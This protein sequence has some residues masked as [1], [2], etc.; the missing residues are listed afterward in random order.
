MNVQSHLHTILI[1]DDDN[2]SIELIKS[3]LPGEGYEFLS[4]TNSQD[5]L[6]RL[7]G[8]K[9][10]SLIVVDYKT[11]GLDFLIEAKKLSPETPRIVVTTETS[12]SEIKQFINIGEVYRFYSKPL[13][14]DNFLNGFYSAIGHYEEA[15]KGIEESKYKDLQIRKLLYG[16]EHSPVSVIITDLKGCIEYVNPKFIELTGY[17]PEEVIGKNPKVL[18]SGETHGDEYKNMWKMLSAGKEWHGEF[19]N[20]KKNGDLYWEC[21]SISPIKDKEGKV[22]HYIAIKEDITSIKNM[23]LELEK[24]RDAAE[25]SNR[26]KSAFLANMSHEL[27]TPMN[28]ILG[29]SELLEEIAEE[30]GLEQ[31]FVPDLEKIHSAGIHLLNLINNILDLSK[32]ES[33]KMKALKETFKL[34]PLMEEIIGYAE[35]LSRKNSNSF[36]TSLSDSELLINTDRTKLIQILINIIG[37]AFKFTKEGVVSFDIK[38]SYDNGRNWILFE[39]TDNGIGM[40][41][42]QTQNIFDEFVQADISTTKNYGGTGLGLAISRLF[43]RMLG[44]DI[45]V[46]S[47][48]GLGSKFTLQ[49]PG[50]DESS[51]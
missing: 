28:A 10:I 3:Y 48:L 44:G 42:E 19:H 50:I 11:S 37:N 32:V 35:P 47:Q 41:L 16:V 15:I 46:S 14:K 4:A 21:A 43:S 38:Q 5:A 7:Q 17:S 9:R 39:V 34:A 51:S 18:K 33:G 23:Q 2:R 45:L 40:T 29:Y 8:D 20:R 22:T 13:K 36:K 49:L 25:S 6:K 1:V 30:K 12:V 27:R 26:A 24:A 31:D